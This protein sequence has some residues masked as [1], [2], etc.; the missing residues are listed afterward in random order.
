MI[1]AGF[2][3]DGRIDLRQ[4]S[5][6]HLN[7]RHAALI[8]GSGETAHIADYTAAEGYQRNTP[9]AAFLQQYIENSIDGL[10]GFI[11]FAVGQHDA[12]NV[13]TFESSF[14]FIQIQRRNN[15]IADDHHLFAFDVGADEIGL[16]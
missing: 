11:R 6:R 13:K 4:Q 5:R 1:D 12:F 10:Q 15:V 3:T 9:L 16:R 2:A 7:K 8:A 14:G